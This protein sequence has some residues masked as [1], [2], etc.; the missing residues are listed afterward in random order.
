M[1]G[2]GGYFYL[3]TL[4]PLRINIYPSVYE[5]YDNTISVFTDIRIKFNLTVIEFVFSDV[6]YYHIHAVVYSKSRLDYAEVRKLIPKGFHFH[7][8]PLRYLSDINN[9]RRY[10]RRHKPAKLGNSDKT[11]TFI[12]RYGNQN[13]E[14]LDMSDLEER[15]SR[16]ER[17]VEKMAEAIEKLS[18]G[19]TDRNETETELQ[20]AEIHLS[21]MSV[22]VQESRKGVALRIRF[23]PF[24]KPNNKGEYYVSMTPDEYKSLIAGL[25]S[26]TYKISD[27]GK[28]GGSRRRRKPKVRVEKGFKA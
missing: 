28:T 2:D 20:R 26:F 3:L 16:L 10:V 17:I 21:P 15:L 27:S 24:I 11:V 5:L 18:E 7:L 1:T 25:Q 19:K 12:N 14:V 8:A 6:P 23:K 22:I 13:S 9:A 4:R